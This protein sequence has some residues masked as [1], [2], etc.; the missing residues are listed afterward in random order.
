MP[1]RIPD[2]QRKL[3]DDILQIMDQEGGQS[4]ER[5]KLARV[6][7]FLR[8]VGFV[9]EFRAQASVLAWPTQDPEDPRQLS[10]AATEGDH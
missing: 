2:D 1:F 4:I 6:A 7:E 3:R 8:R 5:F 9:Q 10:R